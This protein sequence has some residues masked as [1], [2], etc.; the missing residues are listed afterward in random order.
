MTAC[1]LD[2][3]RQVPSAAIIGI[4]S[5]VHIVDEL[6]LK[7]AAMLHLIDIPNVWHRLGEQLPNNGL[8]LSSVTWDPQQG[9]VTALS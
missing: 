5:R 3:D 2:R 4:P 9:P 1:A 6:G 7:E 8:N